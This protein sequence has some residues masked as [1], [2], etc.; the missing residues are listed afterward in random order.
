MGDHH[1]QL[2]ILCPKHNPKAKAI[3]GFIIIIP[4]SSV[5]PSVFSSVSTTEEG[6]EPTAGSPAACLG[7]GSSDVTEPFVTDKLAEKPFKMENFLL[8]ET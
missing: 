4:I 1:G 2:S 7:A 5:V 8:I 3:L 6:P